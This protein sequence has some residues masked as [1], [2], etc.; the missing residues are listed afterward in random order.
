[1]PCPTT[2][3]ATDVITQRAL[4]RTTG[5]NFLNARAFIEE[6]FPPEGMSQ[7]LARL[8]D[9]D[10]ALFTGE[11]RSK[12]WHDLE[13]Y[14]RLIRAIDATLG[15]GDLSL[16]ATL[17]RYEA[18][19][20]RTFVQGLFLRMASPGW[21]VR[22]VMEYWRAFHDSGH[23][24]VETVGQRMLRGELRDFGVPD[25]AFCRELTGYVARVMEFAGGRNAR[26]THPQCRGRG[27]PGCHFQL[28]WDR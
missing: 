1:V 9:A 3:R 7:V 17:G 5:V 27:D 8:S 13:T 19:R 18:E 25:E 12:D 14:I 16:L 24:T 10:R 2:H 21:A 20:D 4:A 23:W 11:V 6:R 28:S 26:M 22:M 15:N